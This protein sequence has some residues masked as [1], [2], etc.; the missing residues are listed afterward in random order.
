[1]KFSG[2]VHSLRYLLAV[3]ASLV[4]SYAL[5][6][7]MQSMT[8]QNNPDGTTVTVSPLQHVQF[9]RVKRKESVE[10][11]ERKAPVPPKVQAA[12]AAAFQSTQVEISTPSGI[13]LPPMDIPTFS[14]AKIP[15]GVINLSLGS[16]AVDEETIPVFRVPPLYPHRAAKR[17]LEG[18]VR[19]EFTITTRGT[20][21]N[22]RV[23]EASPKGI[24]EH[25]ALRA[26]SR[27]KFKPKLVNGLAVERLGD[28]LFT[29]KLEGKKK[30][31]SCG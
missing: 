28:Q 26:I 10:V 23:L 7:F 25:A 19:V 2:F 13:A 24:F 8:L 3:V 12:P 9:V 5:F 18:W 20:V 17:G 29:F 30:C 27:W 4:V 22:A 1:M 6:Y 11:K 21:R 31:P 14:G 15:T 16:I